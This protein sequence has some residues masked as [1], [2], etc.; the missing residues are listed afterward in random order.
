MSAEPSSLS[1]ARRGRPRRARR[2][3]MLALVAVSM[4]IFIVCIVFSVD[5]AYMHL[6]RTELRTAVD[7]ATRAAAQTLSETQS[8]AAA[9][10]A[11]IDLSAT[12]NVGGR[13]F[14]LPAGDVVFGRVA[15]TLS[16]T[17]AFQSGIN[18]PN[19]V[20]IESGRTRGRPDGPV[21]LFL[22][23]LLGRN[24]FEPVQSAVA[25]Q[26]DRDIALVLD[27]S[28]SMQGSKFNGLT[29]ALTVFLSELTSTP[30]REQVSLTTYSTSS[31]R[32]QALTPDMALIQAAFARKR[33][34]GNTAIGFGL[35]DGLRSL[36]SDPL[37]RPF[38][39]P[40]VVLM[41]DGIHNTGVDPETIART[42][43]ANVTIHTITFGADAE[44]ARMQR[45]AAIGHGR[46][47]HA[48]D[49]ATLQ[50]VFQEIAAGIP[51]VLTE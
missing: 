49:N 35:R 23:R 39:E 20:R 36:A 6:T 48:P 32:D 41:T 19:A 45:V 25:A 5:V 50:T 38:A 40:I 8:V 18:P 44:I 1:A 12:H 14:T 30:Q 37:R 7:A 28:G 17:S 26:L 29:Q 33:A 24:D 15:L 34:S 43:P 11:A 21:G 3:A 9:T 51:V 27:V 22:A 13:P 31:T 42:A 2:G 47:F 10:Q 46:H 4:V 16:G